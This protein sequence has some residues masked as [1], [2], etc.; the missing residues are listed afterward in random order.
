MFIHGQSDI[1]TYNYF[2]G[3]LVS[4]LQDMDFQQLRLGL[5]DEFAMRKSLAFSFRGAALL[6]CTQHLKRNTEHCAREST[7]L[8]S[9]VDTRYVD[10]DLCCFMKVY[11]SSL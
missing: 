1:D 3:R 4:K 7:G 8:S 10:A 6:A 5:D 9:L 11:K 2:F